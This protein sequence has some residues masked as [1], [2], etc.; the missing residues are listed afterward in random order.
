[1]RRRS[2]LLK[3]FAVATLGVE[4]MT[5]I[6][7]K[8]C[9]ESQVQANWNRVAK[10]L[11]DSGLGEIEDIGAAVNPVALMGKLSNGKMCWIPVAAATM[12]RINGILLSSITG[13]V[14]G[15][16][17]VIIKTTGNYIGTDDSGAC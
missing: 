6:D 3:V 12:N 1:M 7:P 15:S 16:E 8:P 9:G 4:A 5:R 10:T 14:G 11:N 17:Q 13:Y 2:F